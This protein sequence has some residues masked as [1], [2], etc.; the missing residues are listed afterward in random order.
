M[1]QWIW[2]MT[3]D[4]L[5]C[6]FQKNLFKQFE[7]TSFA[8]LDFNP[9]KV[10]YGSGSIMGLQS[11]DQFCLSD[12]H[13]LPNTKF[14]GTF[15]TLGLNAL[16]SQG[17]VGLAPSNQGS[18]SQ[19]LMDQ[20]KIHRMINQTVFSLLIDEN[21]LVSKMTIGGYDFMK[22]SKGNLYWHKILNNKYWTLPINQISIGNTKINQIAKQVIID[23]G[24]S[25]LLVP[26]C[27]L[28]EKNKLLQRIFNRL[29]IILHF[30]YQTV[31][32][33]LYFKDQLN[34]IA[35]LTNTQ[36]YLV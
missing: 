6:Q 29:Q 32:L 8:Y 35:M 7:S 31:R 25:Y 10:T 22:Y 24:T 26:T 9:T 21:S 34:V 5:T 14:L 17:I 12:N 13:C 19:M 27:K 11:Q 3:S 16:I 20:L 1:F 36:R 33:P 23:S 15:K 28:Q 18:Q 4:C 2:V 30:L